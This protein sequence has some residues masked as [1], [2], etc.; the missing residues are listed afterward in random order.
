MA[1]IVADSVDIPTAGT[2]VQLKNSPARVLSILF[3]ARAGNGGLIYIGDVTV[4]AAV[5]VELS[6]GEALT[7][8]IS[9]SVQEGGKTH[10]VPL[11]DFYA[12]TSNSGDDVDYIAL[13][14]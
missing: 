14:E 1:R 11:S 3:K 2:R 7:L 9:D 12:D 13:V 4:A 10:T 6:A 8:P 5:G